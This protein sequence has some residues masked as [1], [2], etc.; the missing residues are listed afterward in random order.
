MYRLCPSVS[1][2]HR[3]S[4]AK[5]FGNG[6]SFNYDDWVQIKTDE[7]VVVADHD[8]CLWDDDIWTDEQFMEV[9]NCKID[10]ITDV[11]RQK[12][13][14]FEKLDHYINT[15]SVFY[16]TRPL[17]RTETQPNTDVQLAL[18]DYEE[19]K[20]KYVDD[21]PVVK[22]CPMTGEGGSGKSFQIKKF[23]ELVGKD[24]VLVTASTQKAAI[25][26]NG[27][28]LHSALSYDNQKQQFLANWEKLYPDVKYLVV[29]EFF[30]LG[31]DVVRAIYDF[32]QRKPD[33][34]IILVGDPMQLPPV[35]QRINRFEYDMLNNPLVQSICG[36]T[37]IRLTKNYRNKELTDLYKDVQTGDF[38]IGDVG[39]SIDTDLQIVYDNFRC[40][41]LGFRVAERIR[42]TRKRPKNYLSTDDKKLSIFRDC[43][44]YAAVTHKKQNY[45]NQEE[46]QVKEIVK[47]GKEMRAVILQ[48][49]LR[50]DVKIT[51]D[52][53]T[54]KKNFEHSY[55]RT[56]YGVQDDA[57]TIPY[58]IHRRE[59]LQ[60]GDRVVAIGRANKTQII[61]ICRG[62][63]VCNLVQN[64][65]SVSDTTLNEDFSSGSLELRKELSLV[66]INRIF[67]GKC[68]DEFSKQH[69][70]KTVVELKKHLRCE[71]GIRPGWSIDHIRARATFDM[72]NIQ[73]AN[74]Y[75][76]LQI[77]PKQL[78]SKKQTEEIDYYL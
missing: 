78:N 2:S 53:E 48:S 12:L 33:I 61:N 16:P 70:G 54:I 64:V 6:M 41:E 5:N 35:E 63:S 43:L 65:E 42:R 76:N 45:H 26:I 15:G 62:C 69:T 20:I 72:D 36:G 68:T 37:H 17:E 57:V 44:L 55:A 3:T 13:I 39:M 38:S 24:K 21:E 50:K 66:I 73:F 30:M 34:K 58:T 46:F 32:K 7:S 47:E 49:L 29:D 10:E 74:W 8:T 1:T 77:I 27:V 9:H 67:R 28:T 75:T 51:L 25:N 31:R 19:K 18:V 56:L 60:Q 23:R 14:A 22:D 11:K 71:K 59:K 52:P 40:R 4:L